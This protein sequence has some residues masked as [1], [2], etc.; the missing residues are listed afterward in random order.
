MPLRHWWSQHATRDVDRRA[1]L[2]KVQDDGGWSAHV[3][4]MTSMPAGIAMLGLLLSSPAAVIGAMP[5]SPL[6]ESI[7]ALEFAI[8]TFDSVELRR[9]A[10]AGDGEWSALLAFTRRDFR[11]LENQAIVGGIGEARTLPKT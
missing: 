11:E 9:S 3:A 8:A 6:M 5:I 4:F 1:V 7:I 10:G 2:A